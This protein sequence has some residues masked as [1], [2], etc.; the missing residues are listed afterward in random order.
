MNMGRLET[1]GYTE[2]YA[3][4]RIDAF[5]AQPRSY[6]V[7]IRN[8]PYSR[9][10]TNWNRNTL[11]ARYEKRYVHLPGLGNLNYANKHLPIELADPEQHV[12]HLV[13]CLKRGC[14]YLLL[15]A[16]KD[17]ERCHRK[18]VYTL[19]MAALGDT[20]EPEPVKTVALLTEHAPTY[21]TLSL[22]GN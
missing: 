9:W 4:E 19:I 13:T 10:N 20:G 21:S 7:D 18:T 16:C 1:I 8:T 5:L 17:Y 22:W 3:R 11:A 6:L 12:S 15:C 2:Q 14:S